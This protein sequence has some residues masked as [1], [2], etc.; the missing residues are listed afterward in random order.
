[1]VRIPAAGEYK[2][3]KT[4]LQHCGPREDVVLRQKLHFKQMSQCHKQI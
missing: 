4:V 2:V 1:M 3:C